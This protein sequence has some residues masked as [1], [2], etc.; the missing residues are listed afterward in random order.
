[1]STT[2]TRSQTANRLAFLLEWATSVDLT[3]PVPWA[4]GRAL[5]SLRRVGR[6]SGYGSRCLE[7]LL[8]AYFTF[9]MVGEVAQ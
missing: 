8:T 9:V 5:V 7:R 2:P 3:L 1:M 4:R 6:L